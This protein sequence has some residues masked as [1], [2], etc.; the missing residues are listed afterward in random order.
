[1][2][3]EDIRGDTMLLRFTITS[4]S[5]D[6]QNEGW[7]LDDFRFG[8]IRTYNIESNNSDVK[9]Q[10][11]PNPGDN[12]LVIKNEDHLND[13]KQIHIINTAGTTIMS[14][15]VNRKKHFMIDLS[16]FTSGI[17]YFRFNMINNESITKAFIKK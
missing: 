15:N 1:L 8:G 9:I 5:I 2:A 6:M 14:I 3:D 4:D 16:R 17:Y 10:I 7:M 12:L 13:I 11:Y